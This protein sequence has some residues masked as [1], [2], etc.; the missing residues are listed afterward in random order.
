MCDERSSL[1]LVDM[2]RLCHVFVSHI[3]LV[4]ENSPLCTSLMI[5][6][7]SGFAKQIISN[8]LNFCYNCNI[9][10]CTIVSLTDAFYISYEWLRLVL[11]C[12]QVHSHACV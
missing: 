9:V 10:I 8:L 7:S 2:I 12:K 6:A 11:R 5:C 4:I 3:E 1:S